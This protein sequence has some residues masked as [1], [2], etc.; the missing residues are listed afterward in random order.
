MI[1]LI[2]L[3]CIALISVNICKAQE[4]FTSFDVAKRLALAQDKMLLVMWENTLDNSYPVLVKNEKGN[5]VIVDLN[6]NELVNE[7]IWEHFVPVIIFESEYDKLYSKAKETRGERYLDKLGDSSI[8]IMDVN[9]NI[10][11]TKISVEVNENLTSLIRKYAL[12]TSFLK[13][14]LTNY[15][16]K[17][18]LTTSFSLALKYLDYAIFVNEDMKAEIIKFANIYFEETRNYLIKSNSVNKDAFLQKLDL[19]KIKEQL[20]LSRTKK[21][22][23]MLKRVEVSEVDCINQSLYN[24]LNYT[25]FKM[26]KDEDNAALWEVKLSNLNL[27]KAELILKNNS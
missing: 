22:S 24:F 21:A 25:T 11:N 7:L 13:H 17:E 2:L 10:L 27:K 15:L 14:E 19:L 23:R 9:G 3:F 12:N 16:E 4:W 18:N 26:L 20:I 5:L 6:E 1:K 8:K